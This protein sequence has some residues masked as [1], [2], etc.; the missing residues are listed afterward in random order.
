MSTT[1]NPAVSMVDPQL[2]LPEPLRADWLVMPRGSLARALLCFSLLAAC[3]GVSLAGLLLGEDAL[4][5]V[6]PIALLAA[7]LLAPLQD[8]AES[9]E[10]RELARV[11]RGEPEGGAGRADVAPGTHARAVLHLAGTWM[12]A[13]IAVGCAAAGDGARTRAILLAVA[14]LALVNGLA[15]TLQ[16]RRF[17]R[18]GLIAAELAGAAI[19]AGA[20]ATCLL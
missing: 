14:A 3:F 8:R 19:A 9:R 20:A 1:S 5:L 12:L 10:L 17:S 4:L 7:R 11:V 13:A 16:V 15:G 18:G 2:L 6:F